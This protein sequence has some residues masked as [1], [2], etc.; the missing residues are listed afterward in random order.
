MGVAGWYPTD[1]S[2]G[3]FTPSRSGRLHNRA[4]SFVYRSITLAALLGLV[5]GL[6]PVAPFARGDWAWLL[7]C[8]AVVGAYEFTNYGWRWAGTG[9]L[10]RILFAA[11]LAWET[12]AAVRILEFTR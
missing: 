3:D 8:G 4:A 12:L 6:V 11:M 2:T 1:P 5:Y 9:I 7:L 10:Q